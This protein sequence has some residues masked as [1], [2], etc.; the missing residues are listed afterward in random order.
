VL[1]GGWVRWRSAGSGGSV[2][3]EV[4][5]SGEILDFREIWR[6]GIEKKCMAG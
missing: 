3:G 2:V 1:G 4:M 6:R 5:G